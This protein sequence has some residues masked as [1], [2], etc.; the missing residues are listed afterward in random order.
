MAKAWRS[1]GEE[2][3]KYFMASLLFT[4]KGRVIFPVI[5]PAPV[6]P[7]RPARDPRVSRSATRTFKKAVSVKVPSDDEELDVI[8]TAEDYPHERDQ[9]EQDGVYV[10]YP[11]DFDQ[12]VKGLD[13]RSAPLG[14]E[15]IMVGKFRGYTFQGFV[16]CGAASRKYGNDL[17]QAAMSSDHAA[18]CRPVPSGLVP[19]L[20]DGAGRVG[21]PV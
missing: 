6:L 14:T 19:G 11:A 8:P 3:W 17:I 7:A 9:P 10:A 15:K 12:G 21:P 16:D 20:P 2:L 13:T 4:P 1:N 18:H 5:E